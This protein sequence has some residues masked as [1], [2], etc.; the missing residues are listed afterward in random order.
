MPVSVS[1]DCPR[2]YNEDFELPNGQIENCYEGKCLICQFCFFGGKWR[3][4]CKTCLSTHSKL[5]PTVKLYSFAYYDYLHN[6]LKLGV[7][8]GT[9][10]AEACVLANME[11]GKLGFPQAFHPGQFFELHAPSEGKHVFLHY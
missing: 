3:M 11:V 5:L 6:C 7:V 1:M 4:V 8:S 10:P 2:N 9:S